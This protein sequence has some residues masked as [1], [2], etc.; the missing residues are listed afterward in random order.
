MSITETTTRISRKWLERKT[1]YELAGIIIGNLDHIEIFADGN[2]YESEVT[3]LTAE[4]AARTTE[5]DGLAAAL[6]SLQSAARAVAHYHRTGYGPE[7]HLRFHDLIDHLDAMAAQTEAATVKEFSKV[8][9]EREPMAERD[10]NTVNWEHLCEWMEPKPEAPDHMASR[11]SRSPGGWWTV[12]FFDAGV[13]G[14]VPRAQTMDACALAEAEIERRG[15][16]RKYEDAL[17]LMWLRD[18]S[19]ATEAT[20]MIRL[21]PAQRCQ[22]MLAAIEVSHA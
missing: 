11:G 12:V 19:S 21:T 1:K 13:N 20:F 16:W 15:L 7:V 17:D 18:E 2:R 4:L 8:Q 14:W 3:R 9:P 5:R 6:N 22:A 10:I